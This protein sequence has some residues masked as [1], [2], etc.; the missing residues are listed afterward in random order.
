[1]FKAFHY[2]LM[3]THSQEVL[4]NKHFGCVRFV[5]DWAL[6]TKNKAYAEK[7]LVASSVNE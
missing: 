3:P 5:Y 2:R 4:L 7:K 1:M 6:E